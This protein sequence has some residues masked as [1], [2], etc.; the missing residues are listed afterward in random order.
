MIL[1]AAETGM[2]VREAKYLLKPQPQTT[3]N[4]VLLTE[5]L[6]LFQNWAKTGPAF[7]TEEESKYEQNSKYSSRPP[8]ASCPF[9]RFEPTADN[10]KN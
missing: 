3:S 10:L 1:W 8:M 6:N 2:K 5:H 7:K 9:A 4:Q